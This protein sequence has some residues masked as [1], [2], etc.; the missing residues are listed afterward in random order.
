MSPSRFTNER[1]RGLITSDFILRAFAAWLL[2][3][4][5]QLLVAVPGLRAMRFPDPDDVM[6]L[7]QVRDWLGGQ[8]WFD[9]TQHRVSPPQGVAMH[10]SR[11]VDLPIAL[12]VVLL[13][14][15]W[16]RCNT[17][18]VVAGLVVGTLTAIGLVLVSPNV[19]YPLQ[20]RATQQKVIETQ[21]QRIEKIKA[22]LAATTEPE[23]TAKL[24][25]Q[26]TA[27][28]NARAVA[29][30]TIDGLGDLRTSLVGLEKPLIDLRN[31]GLISIPLGFLA[32][33]L[34]SLLYR[35]RRAED[36][37]DE[38]FVRS[39]TGIGRAAAAAH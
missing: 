17:A 29:K 2:I 23:A 32:V 18:G 26:L 6:R 9:L 19:V 8:G 20:V 3:A 15:Y 13:T 39:N 1:R 12:P 27:A 21:T 31:P 16:K 34:G 37:W 28:E 10:W 33:F 4:A 38:L 22:D 30:K 11:L 36:I 7:V 14:L 35:D 25:K 24:Q 5:L